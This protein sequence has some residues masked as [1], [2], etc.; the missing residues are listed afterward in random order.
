MEAGCALEVLTIA[1]RPS[2]KLTIDITFMLIKCL[3]QNS[4]LTRVLCLNYILKHFLL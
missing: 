1:N 3:D 4:K 2:D